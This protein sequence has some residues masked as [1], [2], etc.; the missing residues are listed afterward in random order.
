MRTGYAV[1]EVGYEYN[2]EYYY[3]PEEG[4]GHAK[5]VFFTKEKADQKVLELVAELL[6]GSEGWRGGIE[7]YEAFMYSC[8]YDGPEFDQERLD[9][10]NRRVGEMVGESYIPAPYDGLWDWR[11]PLGLNEEQR[12]EAAKMIVDLGVVLYE[13][14]E[15]EVDE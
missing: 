15:V 8:D 1:Q 3:R 2:D 7:G 11:F 5:F 9:E 14:I 6:K 12:L 10:F 4:G 13:V